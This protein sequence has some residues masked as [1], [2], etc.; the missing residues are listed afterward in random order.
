MNFKKREILNLHIEKDVSGCRVFAP[1]F[2]V[3]SV[4]VKQPDDSIAPFALANVMT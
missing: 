1:R 4:V 3:D 2:L